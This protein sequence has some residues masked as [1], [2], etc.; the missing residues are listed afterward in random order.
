M[1]AHALWAPPFAAL[2]FLLTLLLRELPLRD[3]LD[4]LAGAETPQGEP[5]AAH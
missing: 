5:T 1:A 3:S 2:A 4:P